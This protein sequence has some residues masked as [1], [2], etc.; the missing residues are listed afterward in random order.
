[1]TSTKQIVLEVFDEKSSDE[2]DDKSEEREQ[3]R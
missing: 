2:W 1:M 3:Y